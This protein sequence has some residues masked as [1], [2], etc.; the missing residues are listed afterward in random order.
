MVRL[1]NPCGD[2]TALRNAY[3]ERTEAAGRRLYLAAFA[4]DAAVVVAG[5]FVPA[6]DA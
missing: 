4:G 5:G 2:G 6:H 3:V 1:K